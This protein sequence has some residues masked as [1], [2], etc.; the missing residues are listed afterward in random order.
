MSYN[1]INFILTTNK[2]TRP[3]YMDWKMNLD[4]ELTLVELK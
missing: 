2:L 1:S 4:I 3:N